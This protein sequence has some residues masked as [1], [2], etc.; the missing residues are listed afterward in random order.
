M[1]HIGGQSRELFIFEDRGRFEERRFWICGK[2]RQ[3]QT[4][5]C[6]VARTHRKV[7]CRNK[8]AARGMRLRVVVLELE[9]ATDAALKPAGVWSWASTLPPDD[10]IQ[11]PRGVGMMSGIQPVMFSISSC[12]SGKK[13]GKPTSLLIFVF[14]LEALLGFP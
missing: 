5:V 11:G 14:F 13:K 10:S 2:M 12:R 3:N 7:P 6:S 1:G 8:S 9:R 4:P